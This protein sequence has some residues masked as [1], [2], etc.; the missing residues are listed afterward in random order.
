MVKGERLTKTLLFYF[1]ETVSMECCYL[2][3]NECALI[4]Y[5]FFGNFVLITARVECC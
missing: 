3:G 1:L 5:F 4:P 2:R